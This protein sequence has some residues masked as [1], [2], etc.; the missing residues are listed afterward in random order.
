MYQTLKVKESELQVLVTQINSINQQQQLLER[1][2][3][4][5]TQKLLRLQGYIE[6]LKEQ[7]EQV[8]SGNRPKDSSGK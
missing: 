4:E 3:Q 1:Q 6:C 7:N 5:L 2:R 8:S